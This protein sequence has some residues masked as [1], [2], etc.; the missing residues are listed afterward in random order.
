MICG[1]F[2]LFFGALI[3]QPVFAREVVTVGY[4]GGLSGR[5]SDAAQK[6][7]AALELQ[8]KDPEFGRRFAVKIIKYDDEG[9]MVSAKGLVKRLAMDRPDVIVG[10]HTSNTILSV[11]KA[12]ESL[13]IPFLV[14]SATHPEIV[15]GKQF[16]VRITFDDEEQGAALSRL[17]RRERKLRRAWVVTDIG[18]EFSKAVSAKYKRDFQKSGGIVFGESEIISGHVDFSEIVAGIVSKKQDLDHIFLAINALEAVHL[19]RELKVR[20]FNT[21]VIG[22]DGLQSSDLGEGLRVTGSLPFEVTFSAHWIPRS[23]EARHKKF[24][25]GMRSIGFNVTAFDADAACTYDAMELIKAVMMRGGK[26]KNA[27]AWMHALR[28]TKILGITETRG[29][30]SVGN[31]ERIIP[32]ISLL[33]S[34]EASR[35]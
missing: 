11:S 17:A 24:I 14:A 12:T 29:I 32:F 2:L 8:L 26:P 22:T 35:K 27:V 30:S 15:R 34:R 4:V 5:L 25:S 3:A 33:P 28:E 19:L 21:P 6:S 10:G 31:G 13:K 18:D 23:N 16:V 9:S 20:K 1:I 7:L